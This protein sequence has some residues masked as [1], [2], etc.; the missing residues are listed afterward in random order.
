LIAL[1]LVRDRLIEVG[2]AI[3]DLDFPMDPEGEF[4]GNFSNRAGR[5]IG[6][7]YCLNLERGQ[8]GRSGGG[9]RKIDRLFP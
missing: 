1:I 7:R 8:R 6:K 3:G 4:A 5:T 2:Q 9:K